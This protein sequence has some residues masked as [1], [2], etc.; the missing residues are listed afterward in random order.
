MRGP[1]FF[2]GLQARHEAYFSLLCSQ[3]CLCMAKAILLFS[4]E[5][6]PFFF[7]SRKAR[8]RLHWAGQTLAILCAALGLGFIISSRTRSELPHLVSWHSWV[9]ALTLLATG[10]QA[11]CGL[12]LLCPRAARVSR[13]ARLKLYH[14][15]CGLV[16]YLMA[17]VT[18]LLGMY[19]VWFQ[20]QIKGAA[21]YLCLAL[22]LY[23]ALVIMHQISRSYLP[24]KKMEM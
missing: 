7:C 9:G 15:T 13:V 19:S 5:Y 3:F 1:P 4:P 12:C 2:S 24:R 17:T 6:S 11:L 8:I 18:V 10:G 23:P 14:L 16:V 21:W 22:P 20:A